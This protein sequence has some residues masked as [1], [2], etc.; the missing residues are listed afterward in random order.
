[1]NILIFKNENCYF[2]SFIRSKSETRSLFMLFSNQQAVILF[3]IRVVYVVIC[4]SLC[5]NEKTVFLLS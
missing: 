3:L 4:V 2:C 5:C 1:M